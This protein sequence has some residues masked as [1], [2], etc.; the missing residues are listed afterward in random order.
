M[1]RISLY[2]GSRR[3]VKAVGPLLSVTSQAEGH[4]LAVSGEV[5]A[6][7]ASYGCRRSDAICPRAIN[8]AVT[9]RSAKGRASKR[10][11]VCKSLLIAAAA[12]LKSLWI[13]VSS[14][15]VGR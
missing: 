2:T 14:R 4:Q 9:T 13:A 6:D 5:R 11:F 8:P 15:T 1:V 7:E 12:F 10:A 3:R